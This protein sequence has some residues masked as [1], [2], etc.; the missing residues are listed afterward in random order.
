MDSALGIIR[1]TRE[2]TKPD[3]AEFLLLVRAT[4][5]AKVS[6]A[7]SIPVTVLVTSW[8]VASAVWPEHGRPQVVEISEWAGV[9]TAVARLS[10]HSPSPLHY[11]LSGGDDTGMFLVSPASGVVSLT[12]RLDYETCTWYNITVTATSMVIAP[13][14]FSTCPL[15]IVVVVKSFVFGAINSCWW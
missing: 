15:Q 13:P 4:D 7:A 12:R 5:H 14:S 3:P 10:T 11:T 2:L 8:Q 6:R 9:G 1:L